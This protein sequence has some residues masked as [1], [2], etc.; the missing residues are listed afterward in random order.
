MRIPGLLLLF[1][2]SHCGP[3]AAGEIYRCVGEDGEPLFSQVACGSRAT[4]MTPGSSRTGSAAGSGLRSSER[5]WLE[6]RA[7]RRSSSRK[8]TPAASGAPELQHQKA[9]RQAYQ[10]QRRRQALDAVKAELRRGY[11]P[12]KGERLR[13]RRRAHEDYI[14]AFCP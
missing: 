5:A 14:A 10:C 9:A 11:R 12:A 7:S 4:P 1:W 3:A 13:H 6:E 2:L 8:R